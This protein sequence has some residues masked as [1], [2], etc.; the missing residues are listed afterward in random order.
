[1]YLEFL[2]FYLTSSINYGCP[3]YVY[4][5]RLFLVLVQLA[6]PSIIPVFKP[7]TVDDILTRDHVP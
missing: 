7:K 1:M 4:V 3:H 2:G 5:Q 6:K